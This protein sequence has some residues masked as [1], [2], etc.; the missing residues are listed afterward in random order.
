MQIVLHWNT[1]TDV[2][3]ILLENTWCLRVIMM[4]NHWD[5]ENRPYKKDVGE[6]N[7]CV[8]IRISHIHKSSIM[9]VE[10]VADQMSHEKK[11]LL[12]T[13]LVG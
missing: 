2:T 8:T 7:S 1:P 3:D 5:S 11:L 4:I 13:I 10:V 9:I 12:S 6:L